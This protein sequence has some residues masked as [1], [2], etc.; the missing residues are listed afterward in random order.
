MRTTKESCQALRRKGYSIG[1]IAREL[2]LSEST[3]HWHVK[4]IRLSMLQQQRLRAQKRQ[5]MVAVNARRRGRPLHP[6]AFHKPGWSVELVHLVAHLSFDGRVDRYGCH[7]YNRSREQILHVAQLLKRLLGIRP[8]LKQ[9]PSQVWVMSYHN[10]A[11]AAWLSHKELELREVI[12][13]HAGW[14]RQW[15]QALFDDEGHIHISGSRRRV[16]A[17]QDD[18]GVL[19]QARECLGRLDIQSRI[20]SRARAVEITGRR[21]LELFSRY[22]NFSPGLRVNEDRRNGLWNEAFEKRTLLESALASYQ[23]GDAL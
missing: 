5:V 16:R 14:Q 18:A 11:V 2:E 22:V 4:G 9:R 13:Q 7:Y 20:D 15:L 23:R 17:S 6:V 10:V 12:R 19:E 3:V 1:Q 21:N 8:R